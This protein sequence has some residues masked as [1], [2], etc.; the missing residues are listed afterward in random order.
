MRAGSGRANTL[1]T[2]PI[3]GVIALS[4]AER[5][6]RPATRAPRWGPSRTEPTPATRRPSA[7]RAVPAP[8]TTP[9]PARREKGG[10][11]PAARDRLRHGRRDHG[12]GDDD[13]PHALGVHVKEAQARGELHGGL[14]ENA[15]VPVAGPHPG[16]HSPRGP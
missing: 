2:R 15:P 8:R 10:D 11:R 1:T 9:R 6:I 7:R 13:Q 14:V 5:P 3:M 4:S 16:V 12:G